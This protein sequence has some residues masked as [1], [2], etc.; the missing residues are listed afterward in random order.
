MRTG[1]GN[2]WRKAWLFENDPWAMLIAGLQSQPR[3]SGIFWLRWATSSR[4]KPCWKRVW[5]CF[6]TRRFYWQKEPKKL[7]WLRPTRK[8]KKQISNSR[9]RRSSPERAGCQAGSELRM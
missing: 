2:F 6:T 7:L 3:L 5:K 8:L 1:R 4:D 9:P